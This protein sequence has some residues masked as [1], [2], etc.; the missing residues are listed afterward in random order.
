MLP[1]ILELCPQKFDFD[2]A[3]AFLEVLLDK[4]IRHQ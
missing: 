2:V 1:F 4:S 3:E